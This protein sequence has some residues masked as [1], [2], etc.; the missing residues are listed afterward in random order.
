MVV[1]V[2]SLVLNPWSLSWYV[3]SMVSRQLMIQIVD[4]RRTSTNLIPRKSLP[5]PL[6][7]NTKICQAHALAK[8]SSQNST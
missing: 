4:F 2:S 6:G 3:I 7:I 5:I 8:E 1:S